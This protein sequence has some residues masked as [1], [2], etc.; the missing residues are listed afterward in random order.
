MAFKR[1]VLK[2]APS[3]IIYDLPADQVPLENFNGG[4][5]II[6]RDGIPTRVDGYADVY[7]GATQEPE[8]MI[9]TRNEL[10]NY[11]LYGTKQNAFVIDG[12]NHID[13]SPTP[14]LTPTQG[15]NT[16]SGDILNGIPVLNNPSNV[17]YYWDLVTANPIAPLPAWPAGTAVKSLRA[18]KYHLFGLNVT[19][20]TGIY[21]DGVL[22]SAAADPGAVPASWTPAPDN[23]AGFV[24][25]SDSPGDIV[26]ALAM[27]DMLSIFKNYSIYACNYIGGN[28]VFQFRKVVQEA[29]ILALNCATT[30]KGAQMVLTDSDVIL[31]DGLQAVSAIDKRNRKWLFSQIDPVNYKNSFVQVN[32]SETEVWVCFPSNGNV[33]PNLALVWSKDSNDWGVRELPT[34]AYIAK[35]IVAEN[36]ASPTYD[37]TP[38]TYDDAPGIYDSSNYQTATESLLMSYDAGFWLVDAAVDNNGTPISARLEKRGLDLEAPQRRKLMK[39]LWP[40]IQG[41]PGT[42]VYLRGGAS[43]APDDP[44]S[45]TQ[46]LP[47]VIGVDQKVDC[48]AEG[49]FLAFEVSSD[50]LQSWRLSSIDVEYTFAGNF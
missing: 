38:Y 15:Y 11:W 12:P 18:F 7:P 43:D 29:G 17:P 19:D 6:F 33:K 37:T 22:W 32:P 42:V 46:L 50:S 41:T 1:E 25:L 47:F 30:I 40:R 14:A 26:D 48:F 9:N 8:W 49:R 2:L 10:N 23:D 3:G 13:L 35:G 5:N 45:W 27:R 39:R 21:G 24:S 44:V 36:A 16:W 28:E 4:T 31:F 20:G 34:P